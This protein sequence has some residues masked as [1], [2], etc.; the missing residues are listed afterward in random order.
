MTSQRLFANAER[1]AH[2]WLRV[3]AD[4]LET[5]DLHEAYQVLRPWLH[6][7]RDR[8]SVDSTAHLAA[9]LPELLRGVFYDGWQ[10]SKVPVR[11][12]AEQ[13]LLRFQEDA[14]VPAADVKA[15]ASAI[16][17]AMRDLFSPGQLDTVFG[18]LPADLR[19]ILDPAP[20]G[21]PW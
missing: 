20:T 18:Q 2:E 10:P 11:M 7:L 9:Q 8:L 15:T 21:R 17:S 6:L 16:T 12:H 14:R 19:A 1:T 3:V 5:D 13:Y 4:R